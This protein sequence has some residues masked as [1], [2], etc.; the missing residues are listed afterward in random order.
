MCGMDN[1]FPPGSLWFGLDTYDGL[2]ECI[3]ITVYFDP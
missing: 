3:Y 2:Y 1:V